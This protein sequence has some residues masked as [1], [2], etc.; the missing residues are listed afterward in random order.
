MGPRQGTCKSCHVVGLGYWAFPL[1]QKRFLGV[2]GFRR[3]LVPACEC[4]LD[5][6]QQLQ[7]SGARD[8]RRQKQS[9]AELLQPTGGCGETAQD[10]G[11]PASS[12][13]DMEPQIKNKWL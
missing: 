5:L 10:R 13:M 9:I 2:W 8:G 7:C 6:D 3:K 4:S 11:S 12:V 1:L